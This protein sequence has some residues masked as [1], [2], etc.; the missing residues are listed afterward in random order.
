MVG[1][2]QNF[3][4]LA[5]GWGGGEGEG[6][7][8]DVL[9]VGMLADDAVGEALAGG[10]A[11]EGGGVSPNGAGS[12]LAGGVR[13]VGVGV[14]GGAGEAG[15]GSGCG[16]GVAVFDAVLGAFKFGEPNDLDGGGGGVLEEGVG[17]EGGGH[18]GRVGGLAGE[19]EEGEENGKGEGE[20][21]PFHGEGLLGMRRFESFVIGEMR[22][23]L[24]HPDRRYALATP[25][26]EGRLANGFSVLT[27][28]RDRQQVH[29]PDE[30]ATSAS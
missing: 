11:G 14:F 20:E 8:S 5:G 12:E 10:E 28:F 13:D 18:G 21:G 16:E 3:Q 27:R 15:G 30:A 9:A 1:G 24:T 17:E 6:A 29:N 19:Q 2:E 25:P 23:L 22:G 7:A 4:R 26:A